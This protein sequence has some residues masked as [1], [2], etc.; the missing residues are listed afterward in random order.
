MKYEIVTSSTY[1]SLEDSVE[2]KLK[3]G[4]VLAGSA[5]SSTESRYL[6]FGQEKPSIV[7]TFHQPM[8][9]QGI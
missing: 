5:F 3:E 2:E 4:W 1:R 9:K 8:I 7:S 6:N